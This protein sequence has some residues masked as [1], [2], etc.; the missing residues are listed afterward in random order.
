M[1]VSVIKTLETSNCAMTGHLLALS[2]HVCSLVL[3]RNI[4][5]Q[6]LTC[7]FVIIIFIIMGK[8][9]IS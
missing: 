7:L 2:L 9:H 6:V 8:S 3:Q 1:I 4:V 5:E